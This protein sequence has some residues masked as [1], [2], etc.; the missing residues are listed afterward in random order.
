MRIGAAVIRDVELDALHLGF[1]IEHGG[2]GPG[3]DGDVDLV[4]LGGDGHHLGAAPGDGAHILVAAAIEFHDLVLRRVQFFHGIGDL[5]IH[6]LGG[7]MEA[8]GMLM[9]LEDHAA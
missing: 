7:F 9:R 5:E 2:P 1:G 8:D 6:D 3:G 4:L